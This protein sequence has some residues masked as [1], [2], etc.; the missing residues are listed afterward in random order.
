[1]LNIIT[2]LFEAKNTILTP[3]DVNDLAKTLLEKCLFSFEWEPIEA[4]ITPEINLG[5]IERKSVNKCQAKNS[6]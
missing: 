5:P 3:E 1:M 6:T 4:H 2:I